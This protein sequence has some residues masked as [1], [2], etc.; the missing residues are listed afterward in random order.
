MRKL[1]KKQ[2]TL[3]LEARPRAVPAGVSPLIS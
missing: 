3:Q 1:G 2:L